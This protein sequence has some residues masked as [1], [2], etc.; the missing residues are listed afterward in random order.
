MACA[1]FSDT[2]SEFS[3]FADDLDLNFAVLSDISDMSSVSSDSNH[4]DGNDA[5]Q[6]WS[7]RFSTSLIKIE[8]YCN[9]T[10]RLSRKKYNAREACL[11]LMC[12][13]CSCFE[14]K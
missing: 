4:D 2:Q 14:K 11:M 8:I 9:F 3:G 12:F 10:N 5:N 7:K 13:Q 6:T 1:D